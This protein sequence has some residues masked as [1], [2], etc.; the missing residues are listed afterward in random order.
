[1]KTQSVK[2][3]LGEIE[4]R[5]QLAKQHVTG[6]MLLPDYYD[7]DQHDKILLERVNTTLRDVKKLEKEGIL[8]SPFIE[9][10]AERCQRAIVLTN[11][12]NAAG[13]AV[14]ISYHQLKT[15]KHFAKLFDKPKLPLRVCCDVNNLPFRDNSFPFAFC[16]EFLHH[17]HFPKPILQ[18][19]YRILSNG[20]F[21]FSEEPFKRFKIA[22]YRQ[23]H[24]I[25][26]KSMLRKSKVIRF[27][28]KFISEE[29]CDEREYGV[30][31]NHDI[32]LQEWIDALSTFETRNVHISSV[33]NR[34][35]T[36]LGERIAI[37]NLLNMILGGAITGICKKGS[38]NL[39]TEIS[40]LTDL[41][42]CPNCINKTKKQM[43]D[44]P[45]LK[46]TP[47]S[48]KCSVC[49]SSFPVIDEIIFLLPTF[50]FRELYPDFASQ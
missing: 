40:N 5:K 41:L 28:E 30:I 8:L 18:E 24:K 6:E 9:L 13:F 16:Y 32:S 43:I 25:Y 1:M 21:F 49:G 36:E 48:L 12:F 26:S 44:Q 20:V 29:R 23:R 22:L 3:L 34:I 38:A 19:V 33:E 42:L 35:R 47:S 14:D 2:N 11:D 39:R 15:A 4:F 27:V 10:G 7:K 37:R 50:L 31:E 45:P 46:Q 17:F